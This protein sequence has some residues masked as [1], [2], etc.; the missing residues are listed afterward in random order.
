MTN[1]FGVYKDPLWRW[2]Y[3]PALWV[4]HLSLPT[5]KDFTREKGENRSGEEGREIFLPMLA[6][7]VGRE[8]ERY[9]CPCWLG[10]GKGD[11]EMFLPMLAG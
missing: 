7:G 1:D 9:F 8:T 4:R 11:R 10:S 2:A 3:T 5:E 6:G